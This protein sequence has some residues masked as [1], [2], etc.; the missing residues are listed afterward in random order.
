MGKRVSLSRIAKLS[1]T[2]KE[3]TGERGL[4]RAVRNLGLVPEEFISDD[5]RTAKQW[6][7]SHATLGVPLV[8][9]VD[10]WDHWVTVA[11]NFGQR[12]WLWDSENSTENLKENGSWSVCPRAVL[13]RWKAARRVA[14]GLPRYYGIAV[15]RK[16]D[17]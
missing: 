13:E 9:C 5:D 8:L 10:N 2:D 11:G 12:V 7:V 17:S 16:R 6:L 4:L 3:G 15:F 14:E 1:Y